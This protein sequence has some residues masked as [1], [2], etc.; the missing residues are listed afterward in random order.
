MVL[1]KATLSEINNIYIMDSLAEGQLHHLTVAS[2]YWQIVS[3]NVMEL[4]L[5]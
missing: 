4:A 1:S 5:F 2:A 3:A